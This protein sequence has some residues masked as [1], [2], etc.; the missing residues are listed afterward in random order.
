MLGPAKASLQGFRVYRA[1]R[2]AWHFAR[3]PVF[4][5]D[6]LL[7]WRRP[8]NLYQHRSITAADRYP[9]IFDFLRRQMAAVRTPRLLSFGCATG[10]EVFSLQKYFPTATIKGIDINPANIEACLAAHRRA[11]GDTRLS[12][13]CQSSAADETHEGYDIVFCMAVFTRWQLKAN[14]TI[15]SSTPHLYFADFARATSELAN[16]VAPGGYFVIRHS[17]FRFADTPAGRDFRCMLTLPATG[18][19]FPRFGP[20]NLRLTDADTEDVVFQKKTGGS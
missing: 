7:L 11:G 6:H 10:E 15:T 4:R 3:D 18:A 2:F 5:R 12:F 16:C 19:S 9:V 8:R 20:D 17:A 14:E 13:E 1:A